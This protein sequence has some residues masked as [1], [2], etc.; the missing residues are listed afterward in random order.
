MEE[1][2]QNNEK[3]STDAIKKEAVDTANQLI[4]L[5]GTTK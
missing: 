3:I 4:K 2:N 1:N 5:G